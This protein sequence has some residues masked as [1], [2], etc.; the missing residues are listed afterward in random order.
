VYHPTIFFDPVFVVN[1][2][3][4][5]LLTVLGA[6]VLLGAAV[7]SVAAGEWLR[8]EPK[9]AAW[10]ALCAAGVAAFAAGWLWQ[11]IGYYRIGA[12]TW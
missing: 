5:W 7:W 4:G 2:V 8:G 1:V 12:V 11:I 9:P 10:R 6:V 3:A